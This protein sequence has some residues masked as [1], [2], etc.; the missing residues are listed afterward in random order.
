M[1]AFIKDKIRVTCENLK[2]LSEKTVYEIPE[3]QFVPWDYK[4]AGERPTPDET[5]RPF[6]RFE[7]VQG[8]DKHFW[9]YTA[10]KTPT[11]LRNEQLFLELITGREG[12]WDA[13][14]PQGLLYLN[15]EIVQGLDTNHR[16]AAV[17]PDTEY[18]ILLYFYTGMIDSH[19]EVMM[20]LKSVDLPVQKLYYDL[21]VPY[22]A[23]LCLEENEY[24]HIKT[25]K[26]LERA[27]NFLDF[28]KPGSK[29]FYDGIAAADGYLQKAY[30]EKACGKKEVIVNYIGHTHIDVAWLWTLAQ[31]KEKVQRSFATALQLMEQYPQYIFM[32]SQPQLYDYLRQEAPDLYEKV[33]KRVKEGRWEVEGAMWLEADCNLSSGESLIRQILF[34]KRFM[35]EEFDVES[36]ILWLPDVFGYSGALP[37][38]LRKSGVDQFVTSKISWNESNQ[39]PY[40]SF[41]WQ[42]IDGTEIFTYFLS[43]QTHKDYK[44]GK[45]HTTYAADISPQINLGTWERYQ[46]KE[47]NNETVVLFGYGDGGGGPTAEML[48]SMNRLKRGLPGMPGAQMSRVGEFLARAEENFHRN[49]ED[50]GRTPRWV[51]E[52][53]LELHRGTYTSMAR[54]KKNNRQCEFLCQEAETLAVMGKLFLGK[55]YP[56]TTL[57]DSWRLLLLNQF[58]DII[59][60][61][62][63]KEVYEDSDRQYAQIREDVGKIKG[64]RLT[65]LAEQVS[66]SG[67]FVYNPN[68]FAVTGYAQSG[69]KRIFVKDVPPMGWKVVSKEEFADGTKVDADKQI[70]V[71]EKRIESP[72]YSV[73]FDDDMNI[74]SIFDKDNSREVIAAGKRGNQLCVFE[75]YPRKHDNWEISNYYKQKM[76]TVNDVRA[77][78]VIS[79]CGYGGYRVERKYMNSTIVQ[80]ILVYRESRRIDF[81]TQIDWHEDHVLLK[82][83]F[84]T[85]IHTNK[86]TYEIQFGNLERP[87]HSNTS[88][89]AAKFEVCA[90]KWGDLSEEGY[91]VSLLND[92]KYGYSADGNEIAITLLKC[93][94]YPNVE[95]DQGL[96]T[97][98]YSLYPHKDNFR[99]GGT[100]REAYLLN[101]PLT[102]IP[103]EGAGT[104]PPE[105]SFVSCDS[106]NI[107]I[108]TVKQA[109]A[110]DGMIVRL[111]DAWGKKSTPR[112]KF[113]FDVEKVLLCDLL[114]NPIEEIRTDREAGNEVTIKVDNFEIITLR[115]ERT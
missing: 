7:R 66:Q 58:H 86:A 94:T 72:H 28:R 79:D 97:F 65:S 34:G 44:E 68:S 100:I 69:E 93:G 104:L 27:C 91:G 96:H 56:T 102:C 8:K 83:H 60:G 10:L 62:S 108:E 30:Y 114:E 51:G 24:T 77:V 110:G 29:D 43:A 98:T 13:T 46:Q 53:Y 95:A 12:Q 54:N 21:K 111:Y 9:F 106:E 112:L 55:E 11:I 70:Q 92:C 38:I 17:K 48:E 18:E 33:K 76:W 6:A 40:D 73:R 25:L 82:A 39:I 107:V 80:T 31:T 101:R 103:T 19:V 105:Y 71:L 47:Y 36:H 41:L 37:Q 5:W 3:L 49:C 20:N 4:K 67:L 59:P 2:R 113:G 14:N 109:E 89:D 90:Q 35:R 61:S 81:E 32:S 57:N 1:D 115:I 99:Q 85:T 15:G 74:V 78:T 22:D 84:P 26:H 88:W 75:D 45:N 64:E 87:N 52:L 50:M 63:I 16:Q 42:G 23:A